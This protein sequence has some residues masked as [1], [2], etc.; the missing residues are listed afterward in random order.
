[1]THGVDPPRI[2]ENICCGSSRT[3]NILVFWKESMMGLKIAQARLMTFHKS[4]DIA[5]KTSVKTRT[6]LKLTGCG[7]GR[8]KTKGLFCFVFSAPPDN[9]RLG[10][11]LRLSTNFSVLARSA[12]GGRVLQTRNGRGSTEQQQTHRQIVRLHTAPPMAWDGTPDKLRQEMAPAPEDAHTSI[13][14]QDIGR[15]HSHLQR[16][17][18]DFRAIARETRQ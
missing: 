14:L 12:T 5:V 6:R 16:A 18:A 3:R 7:Q 13:S 1:M 8:K 15:L 4:C 2:G 10:G 9:V 17:S 11:D